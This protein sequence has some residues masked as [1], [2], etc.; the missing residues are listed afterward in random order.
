MQVLRGEGACRMN[1]NLVSLGKAAGLL[2][3][4]ALN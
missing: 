1:A 3:G 4:G 2:G